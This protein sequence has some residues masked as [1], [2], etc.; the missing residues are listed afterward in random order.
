MTPFTFN[1]P[2]FNSRRQHETILLLA[3]IVSLLITVKSVRAQGNVKNLLFHEPD[4]TVFI[5]VEK[6]PEFPGGFDALKAY[7]LTNVQYPSEAK[8]LGVKGR[9]F[10]Y[11][12]V[13]TDGRIT[14]IDLLKGLGFG[15][16]DEAIRVVKAMPRWIPGSQSG[17]PL[18][19]KYTLP[20]LF[21]IDYPKVKVR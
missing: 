12:T 20:V 18:R 7:L 6:Q 8:K 1:K 3:L 2:D 10:V 9:V 21:G 19:V 11:F 13:E 15:C 14:T 5:I 4:T 16:D 17:R